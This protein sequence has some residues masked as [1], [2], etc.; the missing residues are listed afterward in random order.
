MYLTY[1]IYAICVLLLLWGGKF[2]GFGKEKFHED[3]TSLEV[4]KSLRGFAAIGVILHHISQETAF[5]NANGWNAPGEISIFVNYG[6][7]F[8]AIFFVTVPFPLPAFPVIS[9]SMLSPF[10]VP[11]GVFCPDRYYK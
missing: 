7:K 1:A 5:Q 6:Y 2:S 10:P 4:T 11:P 9:L 3:S 8:V